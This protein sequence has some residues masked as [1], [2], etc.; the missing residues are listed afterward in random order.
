MAKVVFVL[1]FGIGLAILAIAWTASPQA[2]GL[3]AADVHAAMSAAHCS[4]QE[5]SL[6][7]GYGISRKVMQRVCPVTE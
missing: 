1:G 2:S 5:V 4:L 3:A 7:E 6:D